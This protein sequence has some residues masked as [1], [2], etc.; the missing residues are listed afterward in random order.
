MCAHCMR[1]CVHVCVCVCACARV[2]PVD[3]TAYSG[4]KQRQ[5]LSIELGSVESGL[6]FLS[7]SCDQTVNRA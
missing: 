2:L 6:G 1:A 5:C 4:V 7:V 3:L